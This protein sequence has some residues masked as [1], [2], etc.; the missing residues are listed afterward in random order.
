MSFL[1]NKNKQKENIFLNEDG[2][3][4]TDPKTVANKFNSYFVKVAKALI[5]YREETNNH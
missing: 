3:L 2:S 5:K 4:I 1:H